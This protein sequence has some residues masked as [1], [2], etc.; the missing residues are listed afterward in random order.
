[1]LVDPMGQEVPF[2]CIFTVSPPVED[3]VL[4]VARRARVALLPQNC[5]TGSGCQ[6][7]AR[8]GISSSMLAASWLSTNTWTD[9]PV[10]AHDY[11]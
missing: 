3:C 11:C 2:V 7:A 9:L 6:I 4:L 10:Y 5:S 1:M 8:Y